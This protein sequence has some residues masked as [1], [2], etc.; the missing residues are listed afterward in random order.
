MGTNWITLKN[1][2]T[3]RFDYYCNNTNLSFKYLSLLRIIYHFLRKK[4]IQISDIDTIRIMNTSIVVEGLC[5]KVPTLK[6]LVRL[7]H[8]P[9]GL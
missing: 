4:C 1:L 3:L 2:W 7:V 6:N 8:L 9:I 5:E